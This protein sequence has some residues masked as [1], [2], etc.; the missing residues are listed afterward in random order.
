MVLYLLRRNS[1]V[2][3]LQLH[4][5]GTMKGNRNLHLSIPHVT[6]SFPNAFYIYS[7]GDAKW[8]NKSVSSELLINLAV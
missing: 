3:L 5:D 8:F 6:K 2:I 1:F 7:I 4:S